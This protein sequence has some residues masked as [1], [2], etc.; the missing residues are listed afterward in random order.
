MTQTLERFWHWHDSEKP[1]AELA[2]KMLDKNVSAEARA[3][4]DIAASFIDCHAVQHGFI[5]HRPYTNEALERY[6][7]ALRDLS[8]VLCRGFARMREQVPIVLH[9][10]DRGQHAADSFVY[11]ILAT[12]NRLLAD[13]DEVERGGRFR[14]ARAETMAR[15]FES[16][17]IAFGSERTHCVRN[18]QD[19]GDDRPCSECMSLPC[20][21]SKA[22]GG[23]VE[24][25]GGVAPGGA[26]V[27]REELRNRCIIGPEGVHTRG[28]ADAL[29]GMRCDWHVRGSVRDW[30]DHGGENGLAL[31]R[32]LVE[33]VLAPGG[34][35]ITADQPDLARSVWWPEPPGA[36]PVRATSSAKCSLHNEFY[37]GCLTCQQARHRE[38]QAEQRRLTT[39]RRLATLAE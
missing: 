16:G 5:G 18:E 17:I 1:T 34:G 20:R 8:L 7:E 25:A 9:G 4:V 14:S 38:H 29:R 10:P 13:I 32:Y 23:F 19:R 33:Q 37:A 11:G 27:Q 35:A 2:R 6:P 26:T 15:A 39:T 24:D 3:A 12:Q 21:W 28:Q 30:M 31:V 36:K 22:P